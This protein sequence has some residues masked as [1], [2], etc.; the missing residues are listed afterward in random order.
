MSREYYAEALAI[1]DKQGWDNKEW[2]RRLGL[3]QRLLEAVDKGTMI[4]N[5]EAKELILSQTKEGLKV[6]T[7]H[8]LRFDEPVVIGVCAHKGGGG[9]TTCSLGLADEL[10]S[11]GYNVLI[12]DSDSQMDTTNALLPNVNDDPSKNLFTALSATMDIRGCIWET[13][14]PNLDIVP[15]CVKMGSAEA[16][17]TS[18][19]A[20]GVRAEMSFRDIMKGVV[21]EN[22]YDFVFV[23]MDKTIGAL[24]RTIMNGCSHMLMV[25]EC[26]LFH[27]TG[28]ATMVSQYFDIKARSNPGLDFIGVVFN[29]VTMRKSVVASTMHQVEAMIPGKQFDAVIRSDANVEKAQWERTPLRLYSRRSNAYKDMCEVTDE[30][31]K[32]LEPIASKK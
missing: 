20:C 26:A 32:R 3:N 12:I 18:Q 6:D 10:A 30:L 29:K 27:V 24:N 25:A 5:P 28:I 13:Q 7:S 19:N 17:L 1:R 22:Y 2:A 16:M 14:Y 11:M 9:K 21:E 23:D 4:D 8:L 31:V 15:S